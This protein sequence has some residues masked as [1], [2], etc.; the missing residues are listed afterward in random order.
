MA[1]AELVTDK[2]SKAKYDPSFNL[3]GKIQQATRSRGLIVRASND[4][5]AVAPPLV[6]TEQ[7]VD[8]LLT[9]LEEAIR[10]VCA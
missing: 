9:K 7:E 10:E 1:Y 8:E 5:V 2:D 6:I 3:G 4:G